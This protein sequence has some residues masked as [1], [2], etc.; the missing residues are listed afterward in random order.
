M[1][2][3]CRRPTVAVRVIGPGSLGIGPKSES[4]ENGVPLTQTAPGHYEAH[5]TTVAADGDQPLAAVIVRTPATPAGGNGE[6][7][8]AR[9]QLPAVQMAEWPA[10]VERPISAADWPKDAIRLTASA[11]DAQTW[12]ARGSGGP[13]PLAPWLWTAAALA[14][15]AALWLR[16]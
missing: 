7:L 8:V 14:A 1:C 16:G 3:G 10:T 15:L 11:T 2:Q 13:V 6:Q 4:P 12:D 9:V 5:L